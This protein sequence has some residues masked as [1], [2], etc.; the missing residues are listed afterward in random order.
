MGAHAELRF[1]IGLAD[2]FRRSPR[3]RIQNP[4][5]LILDWD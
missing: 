2:S 3:G 1:G 5:P 4:E